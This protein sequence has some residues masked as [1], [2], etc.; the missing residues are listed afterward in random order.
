MR[1]DPEL[2]DQLGTLAVVI[3]THPA[4]MENGM[5]RRAVESV[6]RQT[7]LPHMLHAAIDEDG[8]GAAATR[9]EALELVGEDWVAFLDSDDEMMPCHLEVLARA[10]V[11]QDADYVYSW[12][13]IKD[14]AGRERPLLDPFS[15]VFGRPFDPEHPVQTTVTVL[16]R[17][18]LAKAVGFLEFEPEMPGD[19]RMVPTPTG[20]VAGEDWRFTLGCI[21]AGAK[22]VHVPEITWWWHHHGMNSSGQPGQGDA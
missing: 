4:R 3:P 2:A 7:F 20:H 11:E 6:S 12:F 15:G 17:T 9:Q 16:V 1:R 22:I 5:F 19:K 8:H 18:E 10:A 13:R 14:Q 21:A